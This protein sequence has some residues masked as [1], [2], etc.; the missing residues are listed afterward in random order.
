MT[1]KRRRF[2]REVVAGANPLEAYEL[3]GY[4][5]DGMS[6]KAAANEAY[7]LMNDPDISR[8]ID[9]G[10]EAAM[11]EATWCRAR[12]IELLEA[13]N[14]KCYAVLMDGGNA[15]DRDALNGFTATAQT[16]NELCNVKSEVD[17]D[18]VARFQTPE[19]IREAARRAQLTADASFEA[20]SCS[21]GH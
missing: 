8:E 4:K 7:K 6:R 3:A 18:K 21:L 11:A 12:A 15:I 17:E 9:K 10:T 13:V 5:T 16:L 19:K 20:F 1:P 2:V 14:G